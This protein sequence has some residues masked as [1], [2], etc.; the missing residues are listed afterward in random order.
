MVTKQGEMSKTIVAVHESDVKESS[1]QSS[2]LRTE[3]IAIGVSKALNEFLAYV[4]AK[5]T[6][7]A[8]H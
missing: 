6:L 2:A 3:A 8:E 1:L 5:G 7:S 4:S